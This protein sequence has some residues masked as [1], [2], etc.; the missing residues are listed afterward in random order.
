MAAIESKS[1]SRR[2]IFAAL[3][4]V[5]DSRSFKRIVEPLADRGMIELADQEKPQGSGQLYRLADPGR[6]ALETEG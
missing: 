3:G 4:M 5:G 1:L 6:A 2:E